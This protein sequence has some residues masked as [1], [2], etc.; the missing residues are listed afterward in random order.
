[1]SKQ[2]ELRLPAEK[3]IERCDK[4]LFPFTT[5]EELPLLEGIIGQERAVKAMTFG[6]KVRNKGYNIYMS[7]ATGTGKTSYARTLI[8][9]VAADEPVPDDWCYIYNFHQP[10]KPRALNLPA[11]LGNRLVRDMERLV[12]YSRNDI[13]KSLQSEDFEKQRGAI[14]ER[15]Q[16][17]S[18]QILE[19]LEQFA[20]GHGFALR[21]T[22]KGIITLPLIDG[23][24]VDQ[25]KF[26]QLS[27]EDQKKFEEKSRI[28][29]QEMEDVLRQI[30]QL[31]MDAR[32]EIS[33]LEKNIALSV[34]KP[35]I[36]N[37]KSAYE[38]FPKVLRYLEEVQKDIIQHLDNFRSKEEKD[39]PF[40]FLMSKGD[41]DNFFLRYKVNLFVN[42]GETRGAPVIFETN[43]TYYNVFG[44]IEGKAQMGA[45]TTDFTMIKSGALHRANG[46]YLI[47]QA[48][49]ILKDY[50]A[51]DALK[52]TIEN[53]EARIENIGE[54]YRTVPITTIKP[55]PIPVKLKVII[56]GSAYIYQLLY[57]YDE[58]FRKLFKIR[59]DFD[60]AMPRNN[61]NIRRYAAFICNLCSRENLLH[62]TPEAVARVVDYSSRIAEDKKKLSTRFNEIVEILYESSAWAQIEGSPTV[63]DKHVEKAIHE[64]I[65]RSNQPEEHLQEMMERGDILVDTEGEVVGQINGLSVYQTGDYA[66]GRPS[67]ITAQVYLGE[68]GVINIEREAKLSGKIH[69]K[70]VL[71]LSGYLGGKYAK[72]KPLTLSASLAF[73]Q[74][75][76]GVDGDS[77]SCAELVA[78]LS[79]ISDVPIKQNLAITGS[80]NQ[81]GQIQP[82]GGVNQKIEGFFKVCQAKG[83]DGSHGVVIPAQNIDNLILDSTVVEAVGRGEF[84]V[85]AVKTVDEAIQIMT[86]LPA[87]EVHRKVE[88]KL[89]HMVEEAKK[90]S[91]P[92]GANE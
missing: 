35:T 83:L 33:R 21:K 34:L 6:L 29:Q 5:T 9:S 16:A 30:R 51:W 27:T 3:L 89:L 67:R 84:N 40:P 65:F 78:L 90:F 77:A 41:D 82:I 68:E 13:S 47:V 62:F 50:L 75:Y 31:E 86:G 28:I 80:I 7:G 12:E 8:S 46:G 14:M 72:D 54:S 59:A 10:E 36:D 87:D 76:G 63:K 38:D 39:T 42:N 25:A 48:A 43:P 81:K 61:E 45:V 64:K 18:N 52:R 11:G 53:G 23:Q 92:Q 2:S 1:M 15:Y 19:R 24:P 66:F 57:I 55:E 71:I 20:V 73:E 70:G 44:K 88:A 56:I 49:D 37:M 79:A 60:T 22:G 32:D 69:N 74:S 58:D 4:S 91:P 26:E 17:E 85:Y